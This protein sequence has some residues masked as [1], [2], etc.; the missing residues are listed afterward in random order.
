MMMYD[1]STIILT[2]IVVVVVVDCTV[3]Y[4]LFH[5]EVVNGVCRVFAL[6]DNSVHQHTL[7]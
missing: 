4:S 1:G 6:I 3:L 5:C 7:G 2:F